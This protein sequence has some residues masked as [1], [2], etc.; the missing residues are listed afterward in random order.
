M[1]ARV[2]VTGWKRLAVWMFVA[3]GFSS[4]MLSFAFCAENATEK[5]ACEA[6]E[7]TEKH[8]LY[9]WLVLGVVLVLLVLLLML[10]GFLC[11]RLWPRDPSRMS[12]VVRR[13][14]HPGQGAL[15]D[16]TQVSSQS[17]S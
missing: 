10:V 9:N 16:L 11:H 4:W 8:K 5:A 3:E 6:C 7:L 13:H 12:R 17:S 1:D 14:E 2:I 15:A